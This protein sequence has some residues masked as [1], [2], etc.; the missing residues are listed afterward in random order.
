MTKNPLL[1]LQKYFVFF[2]LLKLDFYE[3]LFMVN[4]LSKS[5]LHVKIFRL[6]A[7]LHLHK[8]SHSLLGSMWETSFTLVI[9]LHNEI[10]YFPYCNPY[11]LEISFM[12]H[13]LDWLKL[14]V[15][16]LFSFFLKNFYFLFILFFSVSLKSL[17]GKKQKITW[18]RAFFRLN[19]KYNWATMLYKLHPWT[20]LSTATC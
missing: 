8:E 4:M 13:G 2:R 5:A 9:I 3:A 16:H 15:N 18:S 10:S 20:L 6:L 11:Y 14:S 17:E 19:G 12:V 7:A 1:D